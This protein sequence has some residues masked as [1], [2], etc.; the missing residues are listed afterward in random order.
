MIESF[1]YMR[2]RMY[3]RVCSI[4]NDLVLAEIRTECKA[5][6]MEG[7]AKRIPFPRIHYYNKFILSDCKSSGEER[8]RYFSL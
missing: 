1:D 3:S 4:R 2:A 8:K 7:R 5:F 6:Y